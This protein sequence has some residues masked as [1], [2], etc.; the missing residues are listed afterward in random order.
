MDLSLIKDQLADFGT[1]VKESLNLWNAALVAIPEFI[2]LST[3]AGWENLVD[4]E[5]TKAGYDL[6][7][8]D[9]GFTSSVV[10]DK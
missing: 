9:G 2:S 1:F 8:N 3:S 7:S 10:D 6:L 4:A 5:G